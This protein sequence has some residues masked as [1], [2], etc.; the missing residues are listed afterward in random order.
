MTKGIFAQHF[1]IVKTLTLHPTLQLL[2]PAKTKDSAEALPTGRSSITSENYFKEKIQ[3]KNKIQI[4]IQQLPQLLYLTKNNQ[5]A[6]RKQNNRV[7]NFNYS[8]S[9][10]IS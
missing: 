5:L 6:Q 2:R 3:E 4:I 9:S 1:F 10:S 7:T 8:S